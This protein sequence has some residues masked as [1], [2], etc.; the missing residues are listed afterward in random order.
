MKLPPRVTVCLWK[1]VTCRE[2]LCVALLFTLVSFISHSLFE[3]LGNVFILNSAIYLYYSKYYLLCVFTSVK[4]KCQSTF[5]WNILLQI[6]TNKNI[7]KMIIHA[8]NW[9]SSQKWM[10]LIRHRDEWGKILVFTQ[11]YLY[12]IWYKEALSF[13]KCRPHVVWSVQATL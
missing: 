7:Y 12:I 6:E 5:T 3:V 8:G 1:C 2:L 11:K 9:L 4:V 13:F 10:L